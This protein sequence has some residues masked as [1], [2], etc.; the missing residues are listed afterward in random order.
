M[1]LRLRAHVVGEHPAGGAPSE[2]MWRK[3]P[4]TAQEAAVYAPRLEDLTAQRTRRTDA[5]AW[6]AELK[7]LRAARLSGCDGLAG[8]RLR[9]WARGDHHE[10]TWADEGWNR[11]EAASSCHSQCRLFFALSDG[12]AAFSGENDR[13]RTPARS[14]YEYVKSE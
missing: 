6:G 8:G 5:M 2:H 10:L 7:Q 4:L 11:A 14:C 12:G 1:S 13:K 3:L 9:R